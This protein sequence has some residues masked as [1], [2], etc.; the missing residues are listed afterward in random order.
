METIKAIAEI[1]VFATFV[2]IMILFL[3]V[4]IVT[5]VGWFTDKEEADHD[6]R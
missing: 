5:V 4:G 1:I 3:I 6:K 2:G